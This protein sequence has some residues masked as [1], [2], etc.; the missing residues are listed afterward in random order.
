[1]ARRSGFTLF[2]VIVVMALLV[3]LAAIVLPSMGAFRSDT[4]QRAAADVIRTELAYA[5]ARAQEDGR[6]YKVA[7]SESN[8]ATGTTRIRRAPDDDEFSQVTAPDVSS[9]SSPA[10]DYALDSVTAEVVADGDVPAPTPQN[11]WVTLATVMPDGTCRESTTLIAIKEPNHG[12]LYL[13][14]RGLIASARIVPNPT[15]GGTP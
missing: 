11:G 9:G 13:R 2:E 5:R 1:M 15:S 8:S 10:V 14:I 4:R 7:I 12:S 6:P 3:L